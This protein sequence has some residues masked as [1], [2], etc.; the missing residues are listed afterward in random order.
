MKF[1]ATLM[2][3]AVLATSVSVPL[4]RVEIWFDWGQYFCHLQGQSAVMSV[5][6]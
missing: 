5:N 3:T 6:F 1:E 4:D 2:A